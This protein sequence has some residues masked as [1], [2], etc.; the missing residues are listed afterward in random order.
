MIA[1]LRDGKLAS[2]SLTGTVRIWNLSTK[3]QI[4]TIETGARGAV[5][6]SRDGTLIASPTSWA[7]KLWDLATGAQTG[8]V[9]DMRD[10]NRA[11]PEFSP[12]GTILAVTAF[13]LI[14]IW[15]IT[16]SDTHRFHLRGAGWRAAP[17]V[18]SGRKNAHRQ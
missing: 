8:A 2:V 4:S 12:D 15:D 5:A 7:V 9:N 11:Y 13:G 10:Y 16:T 14:E 17:V 3:S 6:V 1:F 18:F